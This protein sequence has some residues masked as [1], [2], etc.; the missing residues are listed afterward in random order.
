MIPVTEN[1]ND[2]LS[3]LGQIWFEKI[4]DYQHIDRLENAW[5]DHVPVT[6][7]T[8]WYNK[9]TEISESWLLD[10]IE[11]IKQNTD[12]KIFQVDDGY[13]KCVGDWLTPDKDF[14]NT[15]DVVIKEAVKNNLMP[16]I[17]MAPFVAMEFSDIVQKYPDLVVKYPDGRS[18][19]CGD[20]PHWGGEICCTRYRKRYLQGLHRKCC[21]TFC[22][23]GRKIY[24][25]RLFVWGLNGTKKRND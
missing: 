4:K 11:G 9:F 18:V 16:G 3:K 13:Q 15:V 17:W 7:Y 23:H 2:S 25:S 1:S 12:W 21:Q 24:Q 14:P 10:H 19:V 8:S 6:G 22:F 5:N 20:F